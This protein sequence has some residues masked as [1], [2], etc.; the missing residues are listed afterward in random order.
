MNETNRTPG[1]NN[2]HVSPLQD[3][4]GEVDSEKGR[5]SGLSTSIG[6]MNVGTEKIKNVDKEKVENAQSK[7]IKYF[8]YHNYNYLLD[9]FIP[10]EMVFK[11]LKVTLYILNVR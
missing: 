4:K 11:R 2:E 10:K 6:A 3:S 9:L 1:E 8:T 5:D 7:D